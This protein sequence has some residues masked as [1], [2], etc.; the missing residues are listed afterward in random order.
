M[1][2]QA[3]TVTDETPADAGNV[4]FG[5]A[6]AAAAVLLRPGQ[7][8]FYRIPE[9][10]TMLA[11]SRSVA[12]EQLRSGRLGSVRQGR[13]RRIPVSAILDYIDLLERETA[14]AAR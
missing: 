14:E 13:S 5:G 6:R 10:M 1:R 8:L 11:M 12:F 7:P 2:D 4:P 3:R 9:V